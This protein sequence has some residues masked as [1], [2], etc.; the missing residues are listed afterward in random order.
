MPGNLLG[1]SFNFSFGIESA[2]S[3]ITSL[4]SRLPDS[5]HF[6]ADSTLPPNPV[7]EFTAALAQPV[8]T[9]LFGD[10]VIG[11]DGLASHHDLFHK[12]EVDTPSAGTL[13]G[14]IKSYLDTLVILPSGPPIAE[15]VQNFLDT[16]IPGSPPIRE[17]AVGEYVGLVLD[18]F[19]PSGP[20]IRE[21]FTDGLH[22]IIQIF[23]PD[24]GAG[25]AGF[26]LI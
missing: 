23:H 5:G 24:H 26:M 17:G 16:Y 3:H 18:E 9:Q 1:D 7:L 11:T 15:N 6:P 8:I 20:P 12:G 25:L 2:V 13:G 14:S 10:S 19:L 4:A 21:G 22:D